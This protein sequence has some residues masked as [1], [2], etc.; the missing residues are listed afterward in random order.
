MT[1]LYRAAYH[2]AGHAVAAF[3]YHRSIRGVTVDTEG[4]GGTFCAALHPRARGRFPDAAWRRLV[5]EEICICLAG[6]IAEGIAH[7]AAVESAEIDLKHVQRWMGELEVPNAAL[8]TFV[9]RARA[10]LR[11]PRTWNA[12]RTVA[13]RL[14][15]GRRISGADVDAIF[16]AHNVPRE[17]KLRARFSR[18]E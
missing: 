17:P 5:E 16:R 9:A 2:E 4:S 10:V 8:V 13:R 11:E 15:Q 6:P 14:I 7:G 12:V 1:E 18:F 3:H